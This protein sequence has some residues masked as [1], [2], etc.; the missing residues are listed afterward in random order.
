VKNRQHG[1]TLIELMIVVAIIG[2]LA[3]VAIPSYQ[4]Y[5]V[6]SNVAMALQEVASGKL[7][8]EV[9]LNAGYTPQVG[10]DVLN[11][12]IGMPAINSH[13]NLVVTASTLVGT[14][15]AGPADTVGKTVT[16]TRDA[17][18][19]AWTC[20]ATVLQKFIA[21]RVCKGA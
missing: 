18:T 20:Q 19:G 14:I 10:N 12:G 9:A 21:D 8:F 6:K 5:V 4:D 16:L 13:I 2:V 7:G 11:G 1:F 3:S 15:N 17:V